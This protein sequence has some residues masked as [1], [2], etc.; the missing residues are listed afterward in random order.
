MAPPKPPKQAPPGNGSDMVAGVPG[1]KLKTPADAGSENCSDDSPCFLVVGI[2]ASA[3]GLAALTAFLNALP[4][5]PGMAFILAQHR[6]HSDKEDILVGLLRNATTLEVIDAT[7]GMQ[8]MVDRFYVPPP[9]SLIDLFNGRFR[10]SAN[11]GA[12][13]VHLPID[14]FFRSLSA[15]MAERAVAIV[16]SGADSDGT[17]GIK[18]VKGG[19]GLVI[20][21]TPGSAEYDVMPA[22]AARTGLADFVLAPEDMPARLIEY[23]RHAADTALF[24]KAQEEEMPSHGLE[25]ILL[26]VRSATGKD[27]SPY[28]QSTLMR[29]IK[30]RM[31]LGKFDNL[32]DYARALRGDHKGTRELA[33][34][35]LVGVTSFFRD[36]EAFQSL[37]AFL[38]ERFRATPENNKNFRAWI[39][40]AST[41]E[42]AY[43]IAIT[44]KEALRDAGRDFTV[45]I[46]ATD[47]DES[48]IA[49]ARLGFYPLNIVSD[50]PED[51]LSSFF[52]KSEGGYQVSKQI[53]EMVVFAV[54]NVLQDPPFSKLDMVCCR[55]LLIYLNPL[56]QKKVLA[57]F[58]YSL[59]PDGL[60]FLGTAESVGSLGDMFLERDKKW[61]IYV[62]NSASVVH[63]LLSH[64]RYVH[65]PRGNEEVRGVPDVFGVTLS[66]AEARII[67]ERFLLEKCSAPSALVTQ[68][69]DIV[70][71]HGRTGT[72]LELAPGRPAANIVTMAGDGIKAELASTLGLV[73]THRD[74]I[75]IR[76]APM[77]TAGRRSG[78]TAT[79]RYVTK[80]V[81]GRALLLVSFADVA[82]QPRR[83][84]GRADAGNDA[85]DSP[86]FVEK[87]QELQLLRERL[88]VVVE[89]YE[90]ANEE[91]KSTNEELQSANEELQSANEEMETA[92]EELQSINEE[93]ATLNSELQSRL[94]ELT[95]V[96][97]DM[98]NLMAGTDI[99]T[100]FLDMDLR[101]RRFTP[102]IKRILNLIQT[103]IGRP[104]SH[105]ASNLNYEEMLEDA[106]KVLDSLQTREVEVQTKE[107]AWYQM[108]ILP[109]RTQENVIDGLVLTFN[110][111]SELKRSQRKA[112]S[113]M[114][115]MEGAFDASREPVLALDSDLKVVM[116][117][118]AFYKVFETGPGETLG[119][120]FLELKGG[121]WNSPKL[122]EIF[123]TLPEKSDAL[124]TIR[125]DGNLAWPGQH[126]VRLHAYKSAA[127][128]GNG[129]GLFVALS[130][131]GDCV[132]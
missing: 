120:V 27:F 131:L 65:I 53:R 92:K 117:N 36:P 107:G 24:Q 16:L 87:V 75:V 38:V 68:S 48:A 97:N 72:Y 93:Q 86:E 118:S 17:L 6:A 98:M 126:R 77:P 63:P 124:E 79:V 2:G 67:T 96:N 57:I 115:L 54:Q 19:G 104:V 114:H 94:D 66:A 129:P 125:I 58:H 18:S 12:G 56:A 5:N 44:V 132:D 30:R 45:Q 4:P 34:D 119:H 21:Q 74:T 83:R 103:D 81:E 80:D 3:G 116:A 106:G 32:A 78:F 15:D 88:Q 28:K 50:V 60:L 84:K 20:A 85:L 123:A 62:R 8:L 99:A 13:R 7:E 89:E 127:S 71:I 25:K 42:E 112:A 113:A 41:G 105:I 23:S 22:S 122:K 9:G 51:R 52:S 121:A 130:I 37:H 82:P 110:D 100:L 111:I 61:R 76:Q 59:V 91:L 64:P 33:Q 26:A 109:Y 14:H 95:L 39:P 35:L 70:H 49:A 31:D 29:R 73:A 90:S 10:F 43:S 47:L 11:E 101:I 55:N 128:G 69:G 40:A 108:R 102:A 46:Y 1:D